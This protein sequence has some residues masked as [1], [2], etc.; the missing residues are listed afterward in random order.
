MSQP[1]DDRHRLPWETDPT[2]ASEQ[3]T[4]A[5][6]PPSTPAP[7][8]GPAAGWG[9]KPAD[10]VAAAPAAPE[11]TSDADAAPGPEAALDADA[12]PG[13]DAAPEVPPAQPAVTGPLL[14]SA[15][16]GPIVG[17]QQA[18][19][20]EAAPVEGFVM[21]GPWARLVA[22]LLDQLATSY[23]PSLLFLFVLDW[24][25]FVEA[26][27]EQTENPETAQSFELPF[28]AGYGVV[29]VILVGVSYLYFVGFW[30]GPG[31]ATPGMRVMKMQIRD[32]HLGA[33]LTVG[34]ATRRWF[35]LGVWLAVLALL[36][37]AGSVAGIVQPLLYIALFLSVIINTRRQGIHDRFAQSIVIRERASGDSA[38]GKGCVL[39]VVLSIALGI[40]FFVIFASAVLP[41][42]E[43]LLDDLEIPR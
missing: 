28:T 4:V 36:G 13:A 1:P 43:P 21:A 15:P 14:S 17:W 7:G 12:T 39:L 27:I 10:P 37:A 6:T 9:M 8:A 30:T 16:T 19:V 42:I 41:A 34:Q 5:W 2:D 40:V 20:A 11:P 22:W 18:P 38:V 25:A 23:L 33:T 32:E 26:I 29:T 31:R 24:R 3:P 35:A